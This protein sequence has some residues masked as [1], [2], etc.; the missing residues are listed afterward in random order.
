MV[1]QLSIAK[2]DRSPRVSDRSDSSPRSASLATVVACLTLLLTNLGSYCAGKAV[3]Q[4]T[5]LGY[6][7]AAAP[8]LELMQ[9]ATRSADSLAMQFML[10]MGRL[11]RHH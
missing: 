9:A 3:E 6:L 8:T 5:Q 11:R 4:R 2:P 7:I 10:Q 1:P